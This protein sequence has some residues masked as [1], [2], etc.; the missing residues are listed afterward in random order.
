MSLVK[1]K[2]MKITS[3]GKIRTM[4]DLNRIKQDLSDEIA[5]QERRLLENPLIAVP[6]ALFENSSVKGSLEESLE[7][8]SLSNYKG[9]L[10]GLLSTVLLSNKRTRKFYI[11]FVIARE[12]FPFAYKK[13]EEMIKK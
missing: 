9:A 2:R 12:I 11:G 6:L 4:R 8:F 5:D 13:I 10:M 7:S 1:S 3:N